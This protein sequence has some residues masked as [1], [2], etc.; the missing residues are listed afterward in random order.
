LCLIEASR[1]GFE[2]C[3]NGKT[4]ATT[5]DPFGTTDKKTDKGTDNSKGQSNDNV[6]TATDFFQEPMKRA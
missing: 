1:E 3:L 2:A 4:Y 6:A 5:A